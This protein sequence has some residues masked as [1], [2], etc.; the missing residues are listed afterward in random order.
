MSLPDEN[1]VLAWASTPDDKQTIDNLVARLFVAEARFV[2]NSEECHISFPAS[3]SNAVNLEI[4]LV[5]IV[6][7]N[8]IIIKTKG[9]SNNNKCFY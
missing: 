5:N 1:F 9:N 4:N 3:M 7:V 8:I 2:D 6:E